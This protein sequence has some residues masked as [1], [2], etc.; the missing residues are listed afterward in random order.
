[1]RTGW[2][3]EIYDD[4]AF[5][6]STMKKTKKI[7]IDTKVNN[8]TVTIERLTQFRSTAAAPTPWTIYNQSS[9]EFLVFRLLYHFD[10]C[11]CFR[12][13]IHVAK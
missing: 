11:N 7:K 6:P 10:I 8:N 5:K 12:I 1:M 3:D 4:F 9:I 13:Y 2:H